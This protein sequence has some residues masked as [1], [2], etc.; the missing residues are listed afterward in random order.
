MNVSPQAIAMIK[1]HEGVRQK[2]YRCPANLWTIG[3]GHVLYPEQGKLK[4]EDRMSVPLRSEDNR[5]FTMDEVD[6]IL[7]S[8]LN[9]FERGVEQYCTVPLTQGMFD[10]LVSFAFNVGLGTLQRSTL[11]QKLNRGDKEGAAEELLKYCMAG[12]KILKGLQNRRIDERAL[13]LS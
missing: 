13:F 6:G 1:H 11:R 8:D 12:G 5:T 2:A 9:R 4:L 7:R 10:G 3:V